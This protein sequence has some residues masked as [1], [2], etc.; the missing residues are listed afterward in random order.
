MASVS[1]GFCNVKNQI[2]VQKD[3]GVGGEC[4]RRPVLLFV[5]HIVV[6]KTLLEALE[7]HAPVLACNGEWR[8]LIPQIPNVFDA[9]T[10]VP[11]HVGLL[12]AADPIE[13]QRRRPNRRSSGKWNRF[14]DYAEESSFVSI[15]HPSGIKLDDDTKYVV[16]LQQ[17]GNGSH[18]WRK[19]PCQIEWVGSQPGKDT[20]NAI[21]GGCPVLVVDD[22]TERLSIRQSKDR[23]V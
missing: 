23:K 4:R 9:R 1:D 19:E 15:Q 2:I 10:V 6:G 5:E 18:S 11:A 14:G 8:L 13:T 16:V 7:K 12:G 21:G 3:V 20:E 22:H 17:V